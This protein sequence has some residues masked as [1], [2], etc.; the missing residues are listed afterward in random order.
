MQRSIR[1]DFRYPKNR[2]AFSLIEL[3]IV[4]VIIG[5][6][7]S[8]L[9]VA[10]RNV[11]STV[12]INEVIAEINNIGQG[13]KEFEGKF[14]LTEPFPSRIVLYERYADWPNA[15]TSMD[16][17]VQRNAAA[18]RRIWPE[19]LDNTGRP[20]L[21]MFAQDLNGD[22]DTTDTFELSGAECLVFFLGGVLQQGTPATTPPTYLPTGF[23]T[24]PVNPFVAGG[25][26]VG[27]FIEFKSTRL[28]DSDSNNYPEYLDAFSGSTTPYLYFSAYGGRGYRPLGDDGAVG[29]TGRNADEAPSFAT[30]ASPQFQSVY[31]QKE[32]DTAAMPPKPAVF[33]N[34]KTY[35]IISAGQDKAYGSGG[36]YDPS[37]GLPMTRQKTE[38]DNITNFSGQMNKSS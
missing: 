35:Q 26:R 9:L 4:M 18:L 14:M 38:I 27:P 28:V 33:W 1:S 16:V 15:S 5:I 3:L 24:N 6:L 20:K 12:R 17:S 2:Q 36:L 7:M 21:T 10:G 23:S 25:S 31:V 11:T 22:G 19:F 37:A 8:M 13:I 34:A 32:A 30:G 29:G